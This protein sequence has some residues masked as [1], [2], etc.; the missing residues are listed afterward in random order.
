MEKPS[1]FTP[2][3]EKFVGRVWDGISPRVGPVP[4][5]GLV[6]RGDGI[7][8]VHNTDRY[9]GLDKTVECSKVELPDSA[10]WIVTSILSD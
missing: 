1:Q 4:G 6:W 3:T 2:K 10:I 7:V 8:E 5:T 9:I